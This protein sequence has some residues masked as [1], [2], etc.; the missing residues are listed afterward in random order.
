M[1]I[2][3]EYRVRPVVRYVITS[4]TTET[5]DDGRSGGVG[6]RVVAECPNEETA[7]WVRSYLESA[8]NAI[9][10]DFAANT[11][12]AGIGARAA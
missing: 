4:Y 2:V 5:S 10:Q 11:P 7:E 3:H 12:N 9:S 1:S 8:N 6:S